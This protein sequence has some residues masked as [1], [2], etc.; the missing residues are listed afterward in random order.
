[1]SIQSGV[2]ITSYDSAAFCRSDYNFLEEV[3]QES[4]TAKRVRMEIG[5]Q[6]PPG[7]NEGLPPGLRVLQLEALNRGVTLR[8]L[9][10]GMT[11]RTQNSSFF[12][13]K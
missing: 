5:V 10:R 7:R 9:A 2:Q 3:S 6:G 1:M 11:R 8:F 4:E 13:K 12:D